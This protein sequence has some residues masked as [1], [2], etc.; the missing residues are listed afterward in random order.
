MDEI[1]RDY[2]AFAAELGLD[3]ERLLTRRGRRDALLATHPS[4]PAVAHV[5]DDI[6]CRLKGAEQIAADLARSLGKSVNEF[7]KGREEGAAPPEP[8]EQLSRLA[9]SQWT[10]FALAARRRAAGCRSR[11]GS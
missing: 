8:F 4:P 2:V 1:C 3:H 10:T 9:P 5:C 6:A 11:R 7:K